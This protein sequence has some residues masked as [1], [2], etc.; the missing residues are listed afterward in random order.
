[1]GEVIKEICG[2]NFG[3]AYETYKEAVKKDSSIRLQDVRNYLSKRDDIQVKSKPRGS[4]SFVSP[5][6]KFEFEIDNMDTLARDGGE[7]VRYATV[8]IGSFTKIAEVIP[9]GNRQPI[10]LI[11]AL[12]LI[13]KS[14]GTPKQ[15]YPDEESSFRAKV[16]FRFMI[17]NDIEHIQISTHAPSAERFARTFKDSLYRRLDG[18]KQDKSD[19]VKHVSSILTKYYNTEH[20]N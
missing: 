8:A 14:M 9:I 18:L 3:S 17:D 16:F 2:S 6:A 11:S 7:G 12:R 13:F 5:G 1:M 20:N 10:E 15:L 19:W 4:N